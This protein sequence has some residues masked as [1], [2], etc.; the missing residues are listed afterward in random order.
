MER[1]KRTRTERVKRQQFQR[2]IESRKVKKTIKERNFITSIVILVHIYL[3]RFPMCILCCEL[4]DWLVPT[5]EM[6][7]PTSC[8]QECTEK[9][10][11][12]QVQFTCN[13]ILEQISVYFANCIVFFSIFRTHT[14]IR[15]QSLSVLMAILGGFSSHF[16]CRM[17]LR[18]HKSFSD[19]IGLPASV[20]R[21]WLD[22]QSALTY[23]FLNPVLCNA[24]E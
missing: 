4:K 24:R 7:H 15:C 16:V 8:H 10:Q 3:F 20:W 5:H 12:K 1:V 19:P 2:T 23:K 17:A 22:Y 13:S 18:L 14:S 21:L 6:G 11:H 9:C